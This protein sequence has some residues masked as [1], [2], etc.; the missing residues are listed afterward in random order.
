MS[1]IKDI[2]IAMRDG[3]IA[4]LTELAQQDIIVLKQALKHLGLM[5]QM[6]DKWRDTAYEYRQIA[7]EL[8]KAYDEQSLELARLRD[9]R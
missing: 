6:I 7:L 3:L 8:S 9:G 5:D 1:H 4:E 2:E